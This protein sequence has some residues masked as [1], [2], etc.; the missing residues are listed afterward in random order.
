MENDFSVMKKTHLW[1]LPRLAW[2]AIAWVVLTAKVI[3]L[4]S[5]IA[6]HEMPFNAA[7]IWAPTLVAA[8]LIS[9]VILREPQQGD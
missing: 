1:G 6:A 2:V 5:V 3:W 7:W 9:W 4:N 8:L